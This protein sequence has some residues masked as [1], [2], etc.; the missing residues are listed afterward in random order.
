MEGC[1]DKWKNKGPE[2]LSGKWNEW[3][4]TRDVNDLYGMEW[5]ERLIRDGI[6]N[7]GM[8]G[9]YDAGWNGCKVSNNRLKC[10]QSVVL[11]LNPDSKLMFEIA[12][13]QNDVLQLKPC[14]GYNM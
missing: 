6:V 13:E 7:S 14:V 9:M 5:L 1:W 10:S 11:E 12:G 8:M 3:A 2:S 4:V